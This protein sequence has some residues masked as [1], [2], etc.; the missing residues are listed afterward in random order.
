[1]Q[2]LYFDILE[3]VGIFH[4]TPH[5]AAQKMIEVWND[6][7]IWWQSSEIQEARKVFIEK[8][9]ATSNQTFTLL[10]EELTKTQNNK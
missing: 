10:K 8:Y 2:A 3:S 7:E 6:I 4:T 5:S 9:A 1:M